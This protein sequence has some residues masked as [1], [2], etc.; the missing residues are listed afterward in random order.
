MSAPSR[1][2][3][4]NFKGNIKSAAQAIIVAAGITDAYLERTN[5]FIKQN[6]RVEVSFDLGEATNQE[7]LPDQTYVYDWYSGRL[8]IRIVTARRQNQTSAVPEVRDIHDEFTCTVLTAFE[9]RLQPFT[10]ALLPYYAV[11]TIR[12]LGTRSDLDLSYMEDYT[13]I[14]F[15]LEFGIRPGA[16]PSA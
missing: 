11:K 6:A 7:I 4:Y 3:V 13:D 10:E 1:K 5:A 14:E 16:W 8:R 9:E 15:L 2:Q 12:P